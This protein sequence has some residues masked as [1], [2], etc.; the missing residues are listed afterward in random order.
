MKIRYPVIISIAL[1]ITLVVING[2]YM[3]ID[4]R[5]RDM[6]NDILCILFLVCLG[7]IAYLILRNIFRA[8]KGAATGMPQGGN[9]QAEARRACEK[10]TPKR[11]QD[12]TPPWEE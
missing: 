5:F 9:Y 12:V 11:K 2:S 7:L 1:L 10:V 3:V 8:I 6:L 4:L